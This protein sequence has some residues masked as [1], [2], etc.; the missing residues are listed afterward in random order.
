MPASFSSFMVLS[1][2]RK[3]RTL[4]RGMTRPLPHTQNRKEGRI[5]WKN[6]RQ[7]IGRQGWISQQTGDSIATLI[8][9]YSHLS[10]EDRHEIG[11]ATN[12]MG[13]V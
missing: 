4:D 2:L 5:A 9:W 11:N 6:S 3:D 13:S 7:S 1:S 8:K 10:L 12:L